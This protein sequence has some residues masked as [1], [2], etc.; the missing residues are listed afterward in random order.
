MFQPEE[1]FASGCLNLDKIV[2][3]WLAYFAKVTEATTLKIA[4]LRFAFNVNT[5]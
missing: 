3:K 5:P 4:N 1:N 2:D